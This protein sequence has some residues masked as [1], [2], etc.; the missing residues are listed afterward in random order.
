MKKG[1][2]QK[3]CHRQRASKQDGCT[4]PRQAYLWYR[5]AAEAGREDAG[6]ALERLREKETS[7]P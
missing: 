7:A 4:D 6:E 3:P 5:R 1:L 2:K